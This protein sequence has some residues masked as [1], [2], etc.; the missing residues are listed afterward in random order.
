MC[1]PFLVNDHRT[2]VAIFAL[3]LGAAGIAWFRGRARV[4]ITILVLAFL[5]ICALPFLFAAPGDRWDI[6]TSVATALAVIVALFS[7]EIQKLVYRA[8][9]G[10]YVGSDLIDPAHGLRWVRGRITNSGDRAVERCRV[11]LLRVEGQR[12]RIENGFLQWEGGIREP[13]TLS[14]EEHLI[15]DIATRTQA[16]GS[17]LE[18]FA[19]IGDNKITHNLNPGQTYRLALAIY[20]D[21]TRTRMHTV[22]IAIG[23]APDAIQ[24][25]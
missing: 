6:L 9:I 23:A 10:V 15:F 21:N 20:G 19:Y 17:P 14:S 18:L 13:L 7:G 2:L 12:S 24:I 22:R 8:R 1:Q 4:R 16:Q 25:L 11:K 3:V 5:S